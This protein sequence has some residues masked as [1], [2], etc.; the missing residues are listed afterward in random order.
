LDTYG[1]LKDA[2]AVSNKRAELIST[3]IAN[4]NTTDFKA[5]RVQFESELQRAIGQNGFKLN[6]THEKHMKCPLSSRQS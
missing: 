6:T 2:M 5:K 3:N 4:V 1:L